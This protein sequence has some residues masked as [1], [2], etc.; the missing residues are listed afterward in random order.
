[1]LLARTDDDGKAG[2]LGLTM[3][4][5]WTAWP[6]SLAKIAF[7]V[8]SGR[9]RAWQE[10]VYRSTGRCSSLRG[11]AREIAKWTSAAPSHASI[12]EVRNIYR[13]VDLNRLDVQEKEY[14]ASLYRL[15]LSRNQEEFDMFVAEQGHG[16]AKRVSSGQPG[17]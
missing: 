16:V 11:G 2:W 14:R 5:F 10:E 17:L 15:C 6:R 13:T 3:L 9:T 7:L 8:A 4:A 12:N 1:M